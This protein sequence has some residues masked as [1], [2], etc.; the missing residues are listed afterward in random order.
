MADRVKILVVNTI[1]VIIYAVMVLSIFYIIYA[2]ITKT[3]GLLLLVTL[4]LLFI[5]VAV[6]VGFGMRCPLT[7]LSK[8][9]GSTDGYA[10]DRYLSKKNADQIFNIVRA[11]LVASIILL[12]VRYLGWAIK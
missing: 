10:F 2:A 1:H 5:E 11:L 7:D 9:Y 3:F 6:F 4:G 8:K 12:I